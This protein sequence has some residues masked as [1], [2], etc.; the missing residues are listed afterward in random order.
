MNMVEDGEVDVAKGFIPVLD[1]EENK[2]MENLRII[3][4]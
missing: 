4:G 2:V 1:L 3:T